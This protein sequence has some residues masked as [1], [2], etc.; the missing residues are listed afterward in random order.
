MKVCMRVV[1]FGS[2]DFAVP[3]LEAVAE[4][5]DVLLVVAQPDRPAGRGQKLQAPAVKMWALDH[6]FEVA[7]PQRLRGEE[8]EGFIHRLRDLKPDVFVVAAYGKIL[9]Q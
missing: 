5:H 9:P 2:P 7:Q 8:G 3:C 4:K 6:D 1:F